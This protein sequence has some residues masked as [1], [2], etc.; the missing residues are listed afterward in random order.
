MTALSVKTL[1]RTWKG[2]R[3]FLDIARDPNNLN[4]VFSLSAAIGSDP[5]QDRAMMDQ[6]RRDPV[7]ADALDQKPRVGKLHLA[8]LEKLPEN[9]LGYHVAR[10]FRE[11]G[12]DPDVLEKGATD[13]DHAYVRA[14]F[15][16]THDIWHVVTG[17]GTDV[18]GELGLQGFYAAQIKGPT[19]P[20]IISAYLLNM[21]FKA[22]TEY[23]ARFEA[24]MV[25]WMMGRRA[26]K[27]F[28]TR[29]NTM[30]TRDIRQVRQELGLDKAAD[31]WKLDWKP[32]HFA[33]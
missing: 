23:E 9:T 12:L 33:A 14:H 29:W 21:V 30:W 20:L 10:F 26:R 8:E 24:L 2:A 19:P 28:G 31:D 18:A 32:R 15:Y 4:A 16:E 11:R 17:F 1:K 25:G 13:N 22:P 7:G 6:L 27:F 3:A 5:D